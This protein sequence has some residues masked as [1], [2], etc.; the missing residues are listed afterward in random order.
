ML[1]PFCYGL[2]LNYFITYILKNFLFYCN[3][4][5]RYSISDNIYNLYSKYLYS[6]FL[7]IIFML[8]YI[9][10]FEINVT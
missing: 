5:N 1:N 9:Y 7:L 3:I 8:F 4:C 10:S 6:K 2:H